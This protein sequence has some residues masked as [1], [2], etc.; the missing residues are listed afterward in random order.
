MNYIKGKYQKSIFEGTNGYIIGLFKVKETNDEEIKDYIGKT[1]TFTG[2]FASLNEKDEYTFYGE[3]IFHPKY[4]YQYNVSEYEKIKPQDKEGI[5]AFLSSDI[6]PGIGEKMATKI[7]EILGEKTIDRILEDK[8]CLNL[9]PKLSAKK[10]NLIYN[11]LEQHEESNKIIVYLTDLGFS[12]Q[13]SLSIYN[14]FKGDTIITVDSDIFSL[15][16][17][18]EGISFL[19]IDEIANKLEIKAND[20]RRIKACIIYTMKN[21]LFKSGDT[22]LTYD[23]IKYSLISYLRM[24]IE[25]ETLNNYIDELRLENKIIKENND[26]YIKEMHDADKNIT[27]CI[28]NLINK[29]PDFNKKLDDMIKQNEIENQIEYSDKQKEAIKKAINNNLLIITGGPGTGKT[30]IIKAIVEIYK[31]INKLGYHD[32]INEI[33]LLAPTGR[34]SKRMSESTNLPATTIHRFLRWDKES[35]QFRVNEYNKDSSK[36]IIVD[37]VSMIDLNLFD[38]LF[39][40]ISEDAKLVLVGDYNQLPSVGP[41][42]V[43]KDLIKSNMI[44]TVYLDLL[45][46]RDN[47]SYINI[48]AEDIKDGYIDESYKEVKNDYGFLRCYNE[49]IKEEI[50]KTC[51]RLKEKEISLSQVQ[52]LAPMYAGINGI[53]NLNNMLQNLFN[54]KEKNKNEIKYGD[55]IFRENDKI[56]QLVNMPDDN[57]F[58]GDVGY[59]KYIIP[60]EKSSSHKN[61][62]YVDYDGNVVKY[63]PKDFNKIKHGYV[64]SIHK[65]QGS[66]FDLVILVLAR[67]FSRMLYRKL[68]YTAITRAK[69]KLIIIGEEEAFL[70]GVNNNNEYIRKTRLCDKLI[71]TM[72]KN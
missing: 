68:I 63:L 55:I 8:S 54:P 3:L 43:L 62:I 64:I 11:T 59:I 34:A 51:L 29:E 5:I 9:V 39:K 66:E 44:D 67:S 20:K 48:L 7:V 36:L 28:H 16:D 61:E 19:K 33:A 41:G 72:Y 23:E 18:I 57:V 25:D 6:F 70:R 65:S 30:T 35:N 21:L 17:E 40:G 49:Q 27:E 69:K 60:K 14:R 52:I 50:R 4:G 10:A 24:E 46:R 45:Y 13:D 53:D 22:Y 1:I 31:E 71:D 38:S 58:N 2:Y 26:Y 47:E 15:I 12:M 32:L 37:E 56:L 42:N